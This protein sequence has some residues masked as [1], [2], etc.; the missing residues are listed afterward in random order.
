MLAS[1]LS[2]FW[3]NMSVPNAKQDLVSKEASL[4][5]KYIE[6]LEKRVAQLEVVVKQGDEKPKA[7]ESTDNNSEGNNDKE[8]VRPFTC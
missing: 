4:H 1:R 3:P 6:L 2:S 5:Q 7:T 8:A